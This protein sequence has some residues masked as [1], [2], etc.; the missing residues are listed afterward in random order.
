MIGT[1]PINSS[2]ANVGNRPVVPATVAWGMVPIGTHFGVKG[3]VY[4]QAMSE[5]F[6]R[7]KRDACFMPRL[8][9]L[10]PG[11]GLVYRCIGDILSVC[12][13]YQE[14][15]GAYTSALQLHPSCAGLVTGNASRSH[16]FA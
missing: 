11:D 13:C 2:I 14:A 5:K 16:C 12:K 15:L 9:P 1:S 10:I 4:A 7:S 3:R 6:T 8:K